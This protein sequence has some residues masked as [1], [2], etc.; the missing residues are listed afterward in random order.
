M[1]KNREYIYIASP[2]F[3]LNERQFNAQLKDLLE[4]YFDV[5]LPQQDGN[6]I[7]ELIDQ[8]VPLNEAKKIIFENDIKALQKV[9]R[10]LIVLDGRSVDEGAAFELGVA[11]SLGKVCWGLKTDVRQLLNFGD[12]PMIESAISKLFQ[13]TEELQ[14][15]LNDEFGRTIEPIATG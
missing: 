10:L 1:L 8:G 3:N 5:Y 13:S 12:N 4:A 6:L 15:H 9:D 7:F 2:L 14:A 11:Y